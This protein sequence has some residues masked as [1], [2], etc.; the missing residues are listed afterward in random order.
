MY[1]F[2]PCFVR[3]SRG[4]TNVMHLHSTGADVLT[5]SGGTVTIPSY[6]KSIFGGVGVSKGWWIG[7]CCR[8]INK[9]FCTSKVVFFAKITTLHN[10]YLQ[11]TKSI[12]FGVFSFFL[13]GGR[14]VGGFLWWGDVWEVWKENQAPLYRQPSQLY[15]NYNAFFYALLVLTHG[16]LHYDITW[17]KQWLVIVAFRMKNF[18]TIFISC[19][20]HM[21]LTLESFTITVYFEFFS[22]FQHTMHISLSSLTAGMCSVAYGPLSGGGWAGF[23]VV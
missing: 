16:K 6:K 1:G 22:L 20:V 10:W 21:A 14:A 13:E 4:H 8:R 12:I 19:Y 18:K 17:L 7:K 23:A 11:S 2:V 15:L 9:P 3:E 5:V